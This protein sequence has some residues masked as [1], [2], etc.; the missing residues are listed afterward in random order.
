MS[1]PS[2][3]LLADFEAR[4]ASVLRLCDALD[5]STPAMAQEHRRMCDGLRALQESSD[6]LGGDAA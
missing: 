3:D 1:G 4:A 2:H 5:H 6:P